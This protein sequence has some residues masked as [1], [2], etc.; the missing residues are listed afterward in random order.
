MHLG[1]VNDDIPMPCNDEDNV[2]IPYLKKIFEFI[3]D[4][5]K[6]FDASRKWAEG[7]SQ[8]SVFSAYLSFCFSDK[9]LGFT[10]AGGGLAFTGQ[11]PY[12]PNCEGQVTYSSWTNEN[13]HSCSQCI[14]THP[15]LVNVTFFKFANHI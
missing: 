15:C 12:F 14:E 9:I 3:E 10:Q 1:I 11:K 8:N 4:K 13:C 5:P 7:F 6:Q 2:D